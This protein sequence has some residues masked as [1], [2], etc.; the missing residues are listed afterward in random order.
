MKKLLIILFAA[1][2][3]FA[4]SEK[5]EAES[6]ENTANTPEQEL[7]DKQETTP[8][9]EDS[10]PELEATEENTLDKINSIM[11][12]YQAMEAN[13]SAEMQK[14]MQGNMG[15]TPKT[16]LE[17]ETKDEKNGYLRY[18]NTMAT[19][20]SEMGLFIAEGNKHFVA[21]TNFGCGPLCS[22]GAFKF[23]ELR[24]GKLIDKTEKYYPANLK[25][26]VEKMLE[27]AKS[28]VKTNK[29]D[30][31]GLWVEIP[32]KGTNI[33]LKLLSNIAETQYVDLGAL[34][35]DAQQ[36]RFKFSK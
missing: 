19:G 7:S 29:E 34:Q 6:T 21:V 35:F 2:F 17:I 36:G 14:I 3:I 18:R 28:K 27:E 31:D 30:I 1:C 5:K 8:E 11:D 26:E 9:A 4:C 12:Y 23:Y 33:K 22:M 10:S 15:E 25:G 20:Y 13:V 24:G 16:F 32:Q